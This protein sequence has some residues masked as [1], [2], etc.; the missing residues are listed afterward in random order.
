M[1]RKRLLSFVYAFRGIAFAAKGSNFRIQL[2]TAAA[3][4][5]AGFFFCIS[6]NE[7]IA[8][9]ICIFSVLAAETANTALEETVNFISPDLHPQAGRI[10]DLAAGVVLLLSLGSVVVALVIFIPRIAAWL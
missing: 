10:K 1:L 4:T 7:W 8:V 5:F 2:L 3:V 9:V 6:A